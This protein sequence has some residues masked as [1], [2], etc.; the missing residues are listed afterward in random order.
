MT[1]RHITTSL[2]LSGLL[3]VAGLAQAQSGSAA[4]TSDVP[5]KAGEASTMT[6]GRPNLKTTN[7]PGS[8]GATSASVGA[9]SSGSGTSGGAAATSSGPTK[10]GEAST[11]VNGRPN[12]NPNNPLLTKSKEEIR[13]EK[14][15]KKADRQARRQA[16]VMAQKG[17]QAGAPAGTSHN[18]PAGNPPF[19]R[20]TPK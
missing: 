16:A 3:A 9:T 19:P 15:M 12:A 2:L 10:A 11:M 18:T 20:G 13:S 14:E 1:Q 5:T 6:Q 7:T 8:T 17:A 4:T